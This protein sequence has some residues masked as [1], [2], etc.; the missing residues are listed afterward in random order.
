[1][2]PQPVVEE[3]RSALHA[4]AVRN[5]CDLI[6]IVAHL[7]PGTLS[8]QSLLDPALRSRLQIKGVALHVFDDLFGLHLAL[9]SAQGIL[10][11]LTFLQS[12]LC[13]INH[14]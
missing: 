3:Y 7:L 14:P 6:A 10:Q 8:R 5:G 1:M 12:N 13:Q 2:I 4:R 11:G 9:E